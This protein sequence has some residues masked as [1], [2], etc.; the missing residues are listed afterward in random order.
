MRSKVTNF[1]SAIFGWFFRSTWKKRTAILVAVVLIGGLIGKTIFFKKAD[2][3]V[4]DTAQLRTITEVVTE[5]GTITANGK[6]DVYSPTTGV[7][8]EVF[9]A[10]GEIVTEGQKLFTV[11]STATPQEKAAALAAYQAAKTAVQQ[12]ENTRRGTVATVDRVHDDLKNKSA[13]ETFSEKETRTIA[14]IANDNAYDALLAAQAQLSSA[15]I[16]YQSTQNATVYAPI[17]GVVSNLS[18]A[19]GTNVSVYSLLAP[20]SPVLLIGNSGKTETVVSVGESDINKIEIGQSAAVKLDAVADRTYSAKVIRYDVRG[21]S[22]QG[23]VKFNVYFE[24]T[25]PDDLIKPG[26]TADVDIVTRELT[27]VLSVP[28]TAIKPYQKGRA[29]RR[30]GNDNQL[31]FIP[32]KVGIKG[33]EFSQITDGLTVGQEI[34]VSLTNEK[35]QRKSL[36]GF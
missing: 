31:E 14:E 24:I 16:A 13:T 17:P 5:S 21:T 15:R 29:V 10:N 18:V 32:V 11:K 20:A 3:Y 4:M 2:G 22:V 34:V 6:V 1:F 33:K 12:A 8:G 7:I 28:N 26:M 19:A 9:I 23:V 35:T 25:D 36:M 27:N 30:I